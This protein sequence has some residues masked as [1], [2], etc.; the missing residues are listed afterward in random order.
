MAFHNI[1]VIHEDITKE[2]FNVDNL[3][4]LY[5]SNVECVT[6]IDLRNK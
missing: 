5:L 3:E 1:L 2:D 6:F 4:G